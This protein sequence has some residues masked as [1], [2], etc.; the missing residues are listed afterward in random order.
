MYTNYWDFVTRSWGEYPNDGL[1]STNRT[2]V[3]EKR[4][5]LI[6]PP[7]GQVVTTTEAKLWSKIN[8]TVE[9]SL[10]DSLI[11]AATSLAE[12]YTSRAILRQKWAM[13][14]DNVPANNAFEIKPVGNFAIDKINSYDLNNVVSVWN[15][16]NYIVDALDDYSPARILLNIGAVYPSALRA[17]ACFEVLFYVGWTDASQ[18]P[19]DI[20]TAIKM[21]AQNLYET[22]EGQMTDREGADHGS[23]GIPDMAIR[24]LS[25]YKVYNL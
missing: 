10:M 9:N 2:I 7:S 23:G 8:N 19:D 20:K 1:L 5:K 16:S 11:K 4:W 14:F 13:Y 24:L 17:R 15:S 22:R 3:N 25:Q 21:I 6:E 18:V 12:R